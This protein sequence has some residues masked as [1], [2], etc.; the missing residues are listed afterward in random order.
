[1]LA[2]LTLPSR[3]MHDIIR[4]TLIMAATVHLQHRHRRPDTLDQKLVAGFYKVQ[5]Y[6]SD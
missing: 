4:W 6:M 1:M 3:G 2:G 5:R